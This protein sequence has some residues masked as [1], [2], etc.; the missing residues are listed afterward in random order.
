MLDQLTGLRF[1]GTTTVS[2]SKTSISF[3]PNTPFLVGRQYQVVMTSGIQDLFGLALVG[4]SNFFTT[5]FES[6]GQAPQVVFTTM[7]DG[8]T[9]LPLNTLLNVEFSEVISAL[10]L[11]DIKLLDGVGA[12][13]PVVRTLSNNKKIVSLDPVPL[14]NAGEDY[15]FSIDGVRDLSG[16]LLPNPVL[17]NFTTGAESDTTTGSILNWSYAP[18]ATVPLNAVLQVESSERID[19]TTINTNPAA[20]QASFALYSNTQGRFMQGRGVLSADGRHLRFA[21]DE[22]LQPGHS[23]TLY[24]TYNTYLFDLAGNRINSTSR[25]FTVGNAQDTTAPAVTTTSF[26]D[27]TV[28]VAVNSRLVFSA[29]EPLSDS[30]LDRVSLLSGGVPVDASVALGSDRRTITVTPAANLSTS[31]EYSLSLDGLCDYAGNGLSTTVLGFT[32]AASDV[33]DTTGPVLQSIVPASNATD[34][35]VT[36]AITI[37]YNEPLSLLTTPSVT[38]AGVTVPGDYVVSGNTVTFT[39]AIDLLG[40]TQYSVNTTAIDRAGNSRSSGTYRFTTSTLADNTAPTVLAI[41]PE[42]NAIDVSPVTSV[43]LNFSE[44]M[45]PATITS[46]NISLYAN[47]NI[48]TPSVFRSDD[49]RQVTLTATLPSQSAIGVAV[50]SRVTDL[51]GNAI[52]P[53]VSVFTTSVLNTDGGRPSVSRVLPGNGSTNW[54]GISEVVMYINEPLDASSIE[55]AFHIAQNGVVLDDE[56]V[57]EVLGNGQTVRFT[58]NTPFAEGALVQVYLSDAATDLANNPLNNYS[59]FFRMGTTSDGVGVRPTPQVFSP[60]SGTQNVVLNPV[61]QVL[62][63]EPLDPDS[64]TDSTVWLEKDY[65]GTRVPVTIS[66]NDQPGDVG[67]DTVPGQ[68]MT[69]VPDEELEL[70]VEPAT[71]QIYYLRLES[72]I[73]D[74]DG[75]TYG[76]SNYQYVYT[77]P[78]SVVDDRTPLILALNPPDGETG[79]GTNPYYAVRFDEA[80]SNFVANTGV[81]GQTNSILFSENNQV[82]RYARIGTLPANTQVTE[83]L[84]T[85]SDHAG[86]AVAGS[87]TFT[88]TDGPDLAGGNVSNTSVANG[89]TG[90]PQN[91]VL[92]RE[93]S[94]PVD[95]VSVN[96]SGVYLYDTS[97]NQNVPTSLDLS[98]DG[99]RLTM[100]PAEALAPGR[101]YYWYAFSL[102]DLSGNSLSGPTYTFTTGFDEDSTGPLFETATLFDGQTDVPTN[103]RLSVRFDEPLNPVAVAGIQ[104]KDASDATVVTTISFSSDRRTVTL[105]PRSLLAANSSYVLS[106]A[107]VED[108]SGNPLLVPVAIGFT[109][110]DSLDN[111]AGSILNWSY[112]SNATLPLNAVLE[113]ELSERIDPTTI[114]TNVAAG[115][116]SFALYSNTQGR[117]MQGRGVL[118][119][120]G[121][122]LRFA[123]DEALQPGHSYTLYVT[124]NTYLFDLAGNRI[125]STSR[126]FTAGNAQ[127]ITAPAVTTAT[128]ADGQSGVPTNVIVNVRFNE[129]VSLSSITGFD[130]RDA[131]NNVVPT[132]RTSNT[133]VDLLTLTPSVTLLPNSNYRLNIAGIEDRSGN[134]LAAPAAIDFTTGSGNDTTRG[135]LV[136]WSF[137]AEETL[138]LD[139]IL[140]VVADE[141]ID[142]TSVDS[143]RF[144]L[145][146]ETTNANVPG[147]IALAADGITLT[148]S[149]AESLE[150]SHRYRLYV[151]YSYFSDLAGN[152]INR[153]SRQFFAAD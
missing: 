35:A 88:T 148:F 32:T 82:V 90:V 74:T 5:S 29:N 52:A 30:C 24:V 16:N 64:L 73:T 48:I 125:N 63:S 132:Q 34:V 43:V 131:L 123:R 94:E 19:P 76:S 46:A 21:R 67:Y 60:N 7:T 49:G 23:Y 120:D 65:N 146:D 98:A 61:L 38:G 50:T 107:D 143:A 68:I 100:V 79:V 1:E 33:A 116:A 95:P 115:Q 102:R 89:A 41:S 139:A 3:V 17:V 58:K 75:D 112:A 78:G 45:A 150:A 12:E 27:G 36:T 37:T 87:T 114:N 145:W 15:I 72:G 141:R 18:N 96:T 85:F 81:L 149:P 113:V 119:A 71:S 47:G 53:F 57:L 127:D 70:P 97:T 66:L 42:A 4:R 124:Y 44:P 122:H 54:L 110:A 152:L 126:S 147:T 129:P 103:V 86:N 151:S 133:A 62:W 106:V 6:D 153:G 142:P 108:V 101:L 91:P 137:A 84:P 138:A 104:L 77:G 93:F 22:A 109:T 69:V 25:N 13:V 83:T 140:E 28:D 11:N 39:P 9:G 128:L 144:Y 59:A 111:L 10:Y 92:V 130:I 105:V 56:G 136:Q 14:L 2:N 99:R 31:T 55:E 134:P 117:F 118:S 26:A 121:R 135:N 40:G 51:S 8:A 20:G 80:I